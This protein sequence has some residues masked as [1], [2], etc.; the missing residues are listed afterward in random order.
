MKNQEASWKAW[1]KISFR[2]AF[3]FLGLTSFLT[4]DI[5]I[6]F[7]SA[8]SDKNRFDAARLYK[9]L[10]GFFYWLDKYIYHTGYDPAIHA[11]FPS[12]N[13]FGVIFF[14]TIFFLAVTTAIG[15]GILD[16]RRSNY[17]KLFY[18]FNVYLRYT[19]AIIITS[20]GIEKLIPSQMPFPSIIQITKP[21][22]EQTR[23]EV[24]W[25]FMGASPGY[26][27]FAGACEAIAGL[28]LLSRRT[29]L[30]GALFIFTILVNVVALNLF[31]NVG[32]I[33]FTAQF[34]LYA[35]FLIVPD[36]KNLFLFLLKYSPAQVYKKDFVFKTKWKKI[37]LG[38]ILVFVPLLFIL[39]NT[40]G[41]IKNFKDVKNDAQK[42]KIYDVT[43]FIAGD[44]LPPLTTDTLR[45]KRIMF[46]YVY[47]GNIAIV[48]GMNNQQYWYQFDIDSSRKTLTLYDNPNK[49]TWKIF[50]Y[51]YPSKN[52]FEL[53]G[54]WNGKNIQVSMKLFPAD[55]IYNLYHEK[56]KL[57]HD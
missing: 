57:I 45:W 21:Y 43:S 34:L 5:I 37:M 14:L 47:F 46:S 7:V 16:K 49:E 17:N 24:L 10:S 15:W 28:L 44:T 38:A 1:Q 9:P 52:R 27:I 26:Q 6:Y 55:S 35:F 3:L 31:Y 41:D 22:G 2:F 51:A 54:K 8:S 56:I 12:A 39:L 20:Y 50:S 13:H 53:N 42:E 32:A 33:F 4:W 19:L 18:W 29:A 25:N 30:L 23:M 48:Y 36:L 40:S 11:S